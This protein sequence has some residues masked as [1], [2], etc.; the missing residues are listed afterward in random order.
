MDSTQF[1]VA[2]AISP[3][4]TLIMLALGILYNN[5]RLTDLRQHFDARLVDVKET[6]RAELLRME[7][8]FDARLKHLEEMEE[9]RER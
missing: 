5:A 2:V 3:T 9:R 8:V 4:V 7:G 1:Y 6:L